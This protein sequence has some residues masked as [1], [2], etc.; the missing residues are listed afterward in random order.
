[1]VGQHKL[2]INVKQLALFGAVLGLVFGT[3]AV[4]FGGAFASG[5]DKIDICYKGKDKEV[6]EKHLEKW[7][8]K[9]ATEGECDDDDDNGNHKIIICFKGKEKEIKFKDLPKWL[10]KGA[11][12]GECD[13]DDD[14]DN[15]KGKGKFK[16]VFRGDGPPPE[17]LGKIGDLYFDTSDGGCMDFHVK[18]MKKEWQ[19]RGTLCDESLIMIDWSQINADTIPE[20]LLEL[21]ELDCADGEIAKT[22]SGEWECAEDDKVESLE[23]LLQCDDGEI[24]KFESGEWECAEDDKVE[25]LEELLQCDDGEI[26]KFES[27]EW[28]CAEDDKVE[29]LEELITC[30]DDEILKFDGTNWVCSEESG[31]DLSVTAETTVLTDGDSFTTPGGGSE[32]FAAIEAADSIAIQLSCTS[33]LVTGFEVIALE[34]PITIVEFTSINSGQGIEIEVFNHGVSFD[35]DDII[36]NPLDQIGFVLFC[37]IV[38]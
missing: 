4:S 6:K 22:E 25:S 28:E 5:N 27:G 1:M 16:H 2:L 30:D 36:V 20:N 32:T 23:E 21:A 38:D 35:G 11:T 31:G 37:A 15:G 8:G 12:L 9:G 7:L 29:S 13:D 19:Q 18:I 34:A 10:A 24:A 14:D 17:K 26:A 3:G 33:G